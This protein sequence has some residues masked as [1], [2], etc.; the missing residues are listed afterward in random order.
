LARPP[1][2]TSPVQDNGSENS[3]HAKEEQELKMPQFFCHPYSAFERGTVEVVNR[4]AVRRPFPKGTDL[5]TVNFKQIEDAKDAF[6]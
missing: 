2:T 1:R 4:F 5:S 3:N 6:Q